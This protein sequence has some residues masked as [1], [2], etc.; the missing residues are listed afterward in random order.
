MFRIINQAGGTYGPPLLYSAFFI[1]SSTADHSFACRR[2]T[3][4]RDAD[5][6]HSSL[7]LASSLFL[8][9]TIAALAT[10]RKAAM[11]ASEAR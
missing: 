11:K 1:A 6:T 3:D 2:S 10:V 4:A 8:A 9:V 5:S 7:A